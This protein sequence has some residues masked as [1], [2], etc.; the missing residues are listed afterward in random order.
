MK[1]SSGGTGI[2]GLVFAALIV[3]KL[4]GIAKIS[5]LIVFLPLIISAG[6]IILIALIFAIICV[7]TKREQPFD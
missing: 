7:V 4:A 1:P 2:L 5:W 6:I 3:L